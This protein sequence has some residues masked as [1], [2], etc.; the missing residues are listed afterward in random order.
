[1]DR[2][3]FCEVLC[4]G[5]TLCIDEMSSELA[6]GRVAE[7]ERPSVT[8]CLGEL[9]DTQARLRQVLAGRS[10]TTDQ[11]FWYN[12]DDALYALEEITPGLADA[13]QLERVREGIVDWQNELAAAHTVGSARTAA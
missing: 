13:A 5:L 6:A 7:A 12:L 9:R 2:Q 4:H 8:K 11:A 3:R 1:M 10:I